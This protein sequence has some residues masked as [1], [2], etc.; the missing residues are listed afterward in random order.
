MGWTIPRVAEVTGHRSWQSLQRYSHLRQTG[1]KMA[2]W[3]WLAL[4]TNP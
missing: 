4:V 1:D 2:A 3:T